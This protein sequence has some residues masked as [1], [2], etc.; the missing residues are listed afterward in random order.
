MAWEIEDRGNSRCSKTAARDEARWNPHSLTT[1]RGTLTP[2][3]VT[4]RDSNSRCLPV[5]WRPAEYP[6]KRRSVPQQ[7]RGLP[8]DSCLFFWRDICHP[9][10]AGKIRSASHA[11]QAPSAVSGLG[12]VPVWPLFFLQQ[13]TTFPLGSVLLPSRHWDGTKHPEAWE[14]PH[15][16][17]IH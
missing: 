10:H 8:T 16:A 1:G 13:D 14:F 6:R 7:G 9:S 2:S 4:K 3:A 17:P 5:P 12:L 15:N 11:T